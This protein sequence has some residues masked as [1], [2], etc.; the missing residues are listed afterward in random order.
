VSAYVEIDRTFE[1]SVEEVWSA[2]TEPEQLAEWWGPDHF[3]TPVESVDIDLRP[4]GHVHLSMIQTDNGA[5]YPVRFQVVEVV[6]HELLVFFSP[7]QPELG[8]NTDTTTRIEFM[9]ENGT[10]RMKLKDGPYEDNF[11]DMT[12]QGWNQQFG[13]LDRLFA[14]DT[15]GERGDRG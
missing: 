3:H 12:N 10:T 4:G 6:Q 15:V 1:A 5:D 9:D 8:L 11:A 2:W 7:A 14:H 13:K